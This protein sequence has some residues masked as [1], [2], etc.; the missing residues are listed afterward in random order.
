MTK[1]KFQQPVRAK[2]WY[3]NQY[4]HDVFDLVDSCE[5]TGLFF[6]CDG[7]DYLVYDP[8]KKCIRQCFSCKEV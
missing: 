5:F 6:V 3:Q 7:R 2:Y 1:F 4:G 8:H